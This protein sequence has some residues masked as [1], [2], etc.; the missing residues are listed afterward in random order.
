[1]KWGDGVGLA[2]V[3]SLRPEPLLATAEQ[4]AE[5]EQDLL[6]EYV[7]ARASAG[8]VDRTIRGEVDAVVELR[9]WFGR[10]LWEMQPQDLDRFLGHDQRAM[11][12][13]TKVRKAGAIAVYFEFLELRHRPEIHAATGH[14]VASPVDEMNRPK[15]G[16]GLHVHLPPPAAE[17]ERLF[18]HWR[19]E[20]PTVRKYAPAVRN[21]TATR[22]TSLIGPRVSELCLL[23][24]GDVRFDLGPFGKVLLRGKG[25][26]GQK[27]E[28]LIPLIN[29]SR[30]LLEWWLSGPRWE[31]DER[32]DDPSAPLFPSERRYA[33]AVSARVSE[34]ALRTGLSEAVARHL[35]AWSGR[36]SP[37]V[38]RHFAASDLYA[39]GVN[40][41]AIQDLLGHSWINTTMIYVHVNKTHIEDAWTAA[42]RR[43]AARF[44]G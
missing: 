2:L 7:L 35:P 3:R 17:V 10:P 29:G 30:G 43:V 44:T 15:G 36:V 14:L 41:I 26:R 18:G 34:N 16:R 20:L 38:L 33:G 21:Y 19:E 9:R 27:K 13:G 25:R 4:I 42:G 12:A 24:I 22:L 28:R 1:M 32:G 23:Q 11:A 6:S 5:F 39:Q 40:I 8:V 31:F 37:H